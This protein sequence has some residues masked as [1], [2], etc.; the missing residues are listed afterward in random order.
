MT[1]WHTESNKYTARLNMVLSI[2]QS[3]KKRPKEIPE[4]PLNEAPTQLQSLLHRAAHFFELGACLRTRE[5][6]HAIDVLWGNGSLSA[7]SP[8]VRIIYEIWG[9][10]NFLFLALENYEKISDIEKLG[11]VVNKVFE[12]VRSE[13]LMPYGTPASEMPI[14]VLDS[15][16][17]LNK[18]HSNA[19]TTYEY[20]CESSHPN[21]PRYIEWWLLG[22]EGDNWS[23][24]VVQK[25]GHELLENTV[26]ALEQS[27]EGVNLKARNGLDICGKL[28][29]DAA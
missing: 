25:R 9:V 7:V 10:S 18:E 28:Y 8:L 17:L 4:G 21:Y 12:G 26:K 3:D 16:R 15:V 22:K 11:K 1:D 23:N 2:V 5:T 20:L 13:V 29:K 24:K 19:L 27:V 6:V 14:H